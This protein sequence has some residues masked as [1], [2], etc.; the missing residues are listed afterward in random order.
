MTLNFKKNNLL[1]IMLLIF[2][3]LSCIVFINMSNVQESLVNFNTDNKK[4]FIYNSSDTSY[5]YYTLDINKFKYKLSSLPP[6]LILESSNNVTT[7]NRNL[8]NYKQK[9]ILMMYYNTETDISLLNINRNTYIT[10]DISTIAITDTSNIKT[11]NMVF[12]E[13]SGNFYDLS[14][15]IL[16]KFK[17]KINGEFVIANGKIVETPINSSSSSS[18]SSLS[19]YNQRD[20]TFF[21]DLNLYL[22]RQG[23]F[24]SN[25]IPPIYNNF[26]TAMNLP[27]NPIVNPINSMNPLE[28]ANTLFGPNISPT[29]ISN[30]C[31]NQNVGRVTDNTTILR[32]TSGN[33]LPTLGTN[34]FN[35]ANTSNNANTFNNANTSNNANNANTS[36]T[37][38]NTN[39]TNNTNRNQNFMRESYPPLQP[40]EILSDPSQE[41][42][43]NGFIPRPVLTDFSSF[44]M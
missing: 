9:N 33:S 36:N 12:L 8:N 3:I 31:L 19:R 41:N 23:A 37:S 20:N 11:M 10:L 39:N 17:M 40:P 13:R 43:N 42:T 5:N 18:S 22:L 28:Y 4:Y 2:V 14:N 34:T 44:G 27:T 6:G 30:M 32:E 21:N 16:S 26:E 38:N 15:G 25:Y 24:G 35:N 29:M 1:I 7:T